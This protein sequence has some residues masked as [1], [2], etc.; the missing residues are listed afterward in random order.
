MERARHNWILCSVSIHLI[1]SLMK[2]SWSSPYISSS[3][4]DKSHP[5]PCSD[6]R[7][8]SRLSVCFENAERNRREREVVKDRILV[9]LTKQAYWLSCFLDSGSMRVTKYVWKPSVHVPTQTNWRSTEQWILNQHA[10]RWCVSDYPRSVDRRNM[11]PDE[12]E[13]VGHWH[14]L[15]CRMTTLSE[16]TQ[17]HLWSAASVGRVP[18]WDMAG[19]ENYLNDFG[20]H[21]RY[22]SI[23]KR[24]RVKQITTFFYPLYTFSCT[25]AVNLI[26]SY[27][28]LEQQWGEL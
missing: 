18:E 28:M 3:D 17:S 1:Y 22:W 16:D 19:L 20:H 14:I 23:G 27:R 10:A 12:D 4:R 8:A 26:Y 7:M 5:S 13:T 15:R 6:E 21:H 24:E 25:R 9:Q 11:C 2:E